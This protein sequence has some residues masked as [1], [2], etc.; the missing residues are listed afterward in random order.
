MSEG[1]KALWEMRK[2]GLGGAGFMEFSRLSDGDYYLQIDWNNGEK[3]W[4]VL[5]CDKRGA[6]SVAKFLRK[7]ADKLDADC[8]QDRENE[9]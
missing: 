8:A 1:L 7:V 9:R 3:P 2:R 6:R 5:A 4:T